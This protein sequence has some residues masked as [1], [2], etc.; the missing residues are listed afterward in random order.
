LTKFDAG[1]AIFHLGDYG[2]KIE[3]DES[4]TGELPHES[5]AYEQYYG[6]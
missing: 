1:C 5:D 6:G 3:L 2:D 4:L